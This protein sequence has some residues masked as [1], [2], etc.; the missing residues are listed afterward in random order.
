MNR[1]LNNG[2]DSIAANP[3]KSDQ[4]SDFVAYRIDGFALA[5]GVIF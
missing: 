5:R 3:G 1:L 4:E 2:A